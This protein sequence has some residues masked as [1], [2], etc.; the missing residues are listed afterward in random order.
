MC[1][2]KT[3]QKMQF[4]FKNLNSLAFDTK[5]AFTFKILIHFI[6]GYHHLKFVLIQNNYL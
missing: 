6:Q 3:K 1:Q 2:N 5:L 4:N